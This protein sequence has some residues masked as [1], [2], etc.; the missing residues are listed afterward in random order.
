MIRVGAKQLGVCYE[1][2]YYDSCKFGEKCTFTHDPKDLQVFKDIVN[3]HF[4]RLN[5]KELDL[6][7]QEGANKVVDFLEAIRKSNMAANKQAAAKPQGDRDR[8]R[9]GAGN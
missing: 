1:Q 9:R 6:A 8:G 4:F 3:Q 2:L 5:G 7:S